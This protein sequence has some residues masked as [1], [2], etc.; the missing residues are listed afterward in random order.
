MNSKINDN[1]LINKLTNDEQ[2]A[3]SYIQ[4][5][6]PSWAEVFNSI[7]LESRDKISQRLIT[8]MH[9]ENLVN[10]RDYSEIID[11]KQLSFT[12]ATPHTKVLTIS[13]PHAQRKLYAPILGQ[14]AFDRINVTGHF[15]LN[16][17][18]NIIV[19]YIQVKYYRV[20]Y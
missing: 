8:S 9:R 12:I 13:F 2:Y 14:H 4:S 3:L 1:N 5:V 19:Y 20:F 7:L 17:I 16:K 15:I 6:N 11:T 18:M 10:C